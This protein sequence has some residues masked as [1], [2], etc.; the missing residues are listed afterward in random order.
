MSAVEPAG[1]MLGE[2]GW[3]WLRDHEMDLLPMPVRPARLRWAWA[4]LIVVLAG[5]AT[6][7]VVIGTR[8]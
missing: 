3:Q 6:L 5:L 1:S 4:A 2:Q 8:L 7:I